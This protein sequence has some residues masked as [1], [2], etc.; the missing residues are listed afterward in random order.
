MEEPAADVTV[1][2][3]RDLS[4]DAIRT[5]IFEDPSLH[6]FAATVVLPQLS[7]HGFLAHGRG[8][9]TLARIPGIKAR[10]SGQG[11]HGDRGRVLA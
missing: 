11:S 10:I 4:R 8:R 9:K 6:G 5:W 2:R 3:T 1:A 7:V